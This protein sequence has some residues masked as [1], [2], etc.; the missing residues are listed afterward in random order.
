M[1]KKCTVLALALAL[2]SSL[3]LKAD[4]GMWLPMLIKR[5]NQRDLQ[6]MGLQLTPEEI[7][8][9]NNSSLKDAIVSMGGFCT[10]EII[11]SNGLM[12]TNH[13]CGYD[14]IRTNSSVEHD[15][16]TDGFWA[17]SLDQE[18][19]NEGLYVSF[20]VR[21]EDVTERVLSE[22]EGIEDEAQRQAKA[23][24]VGTM[25]AEEAQAGTHYT[26]Q[27]KSFY[28][29]N[30]FYMFVYETFT[31][32]RLVGAPPSSIGKYG[33]DTDNWMWPRQ[34]GDFSL[35]RVYTGPD[36]KPAEYSTDNVPLKPKH[37][38]P[39]NIAGIE[40]GDFTMTFGYP[41]STDRYLTSYGVDQALEKK[42]PT[43][44]EIR[45][46]K[47]AALRKDMKESDA[48]RI[49]YASK[50]AQIANYWK[51][52]IGQTEQLKRLN[53][54]D[55]KRE[56]EAAFQA[57]ADADPN[58]KAKY[59]EALSM[60]KQGYADTDARVIGNTYVVEAGL[61]GADAILFTFRFNRRLD[62]YM[63][64]EE[65]AEKDA[66]KAELIEAAKQHFTE[67]NVPTDM[68]LFAVTNELYSK[69]VETDQQPQYLQDLGDKYEGKWDDYAEKV[70]DQSIFTNE[71]RLIAFIEKPKA[72]TLE[73]DMM[74]QVA[75]D[76]FTVYRGSAQ[77]SAGA[78]AMM[79]KGNRLFQAGLIEMNP[80]K[81]FYPDANS[82]M[83]ASFGNVK[84]YFPKDGVKYKYFTTMEGLMAK[85]DP[86]ND[87]FIVPAK[88]KELYEAKDYG[89]YADKDGT[90]HVN[91]IST[92]DI[93]G[94]NSGSPVIN[95]NGELI[96][97]A[98][99]GNWEAM[100]GDINFEPSVQRTIS[101]DIRYVLFVV[102]K[103][104][105][106]S[107]LIDEMTLVKEK[108]MKKADMMTEHPEKVEKKVDEV[109]K[110]PVMN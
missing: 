22:L 48:V 63:Q 36:G 103:F 27:V 78:E 44:V 4:E 85:E 14:A 106:A 12:L 86:N 50:Y 17:K 58:R 96:G 25:I 71:E 66:V 31:D 98:F 108:P 35:F 55:Q 45:D 53:V 75:N 39:V 79:D 88:L 57:W 97:L 5:L 16:L 93:T 15:Y 21:M 32:V 67:V 46:A 110:T 40:D 76:L 82:T 6:E 89:Q 1:I 77:A 47:L 72:K 62:A 23:S 18:L 42:N 13:H 99:D 68:S 52:F 92:N 69:N 91:F 28:K 109:E 51:Y 80:D 3:P 95:G 41:G 74:I 104:A 56:L 11:S 10:G 30:E 19:P 64:M 26:A 60:I 54:A 29:G 38:L 7:Y 87:E 34:T 8:S 9:V 102:D 84:S 94:G 81:D 90:L 73:K 107:N 83:R 70:Y 100:S 37:H 20:L 43:I 2:I 59:G 65:G 61:L 24:E 101:V 33:G 49:M 105:G